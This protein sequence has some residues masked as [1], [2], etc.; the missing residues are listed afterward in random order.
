MLETETVLDRR[1]LRRSVSFWRGAGIAALALAIGALAFGPD[2]FTALGEAKQIAR[3][4]VEGTITEDR[5][6]LK[7]LKDIA[8][9]DHVAVA[10][11]LAS[12]PDTS[13]QTLAERMV[14]LRPQLDY[15]PPAAVGGAAD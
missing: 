7:M 15:N 1:K 10:N 3:V 14:A 6:Q 13:A 12:R 9:A 5:D 8:D 11:A 2:K 4:T